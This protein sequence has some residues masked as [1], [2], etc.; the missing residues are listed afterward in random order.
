[1]YE[2]PYGNSQQLNLDW[3]LNK[4]KEFENSGASSADMKSIA[5]ALL[6]ASYDAGSAY[7]VNDVVYNDTLKT[8]YICN[9]AIPV[10]GEPWDAT[11]W[12]AFRV[13]EVLTFLFNTI[14]NLPSDNIANNS[15][16]TGT[17]LTAALNALVEDIKYS[18]HYLQQKKNGVYTDVIPIEDTPS[19]NSDRLASSKAAYD[20]KGAINYVLFPTGNQ[21]DR[22]AEIQAKLNTYGICELAEGEYYISAPIVMGDGQTLK[23]RNR[24]SIIHAPSATG[25]IDILNNVTNVT[26]VGLQLKGDNT[27]RPSVEGTDYPYGINFA[28]GTSASATIDNCY[29]NGLNRGI[30]TVSG[31]SVG[32][33]TNLSISDCAFKYCNVGIYFQPN[34]EYYS[35]TNCTFTK[36]FFGAEVS[37]GNNKFAC[38]T[39]SSNSIGLILYADNGSPQNN[40]HGSAVGCSFNHNTNKGISASNITYGYVF[41]ACNIFY[42]D[43]GL[44]NSSGI[45]FESCIIMGHSSADNH[46]DIIL[47]NCSGSVTFNDCIYI[48]EPTIT[49][50]NSP[51][52]S[53]MN[54][55]TID[56]EIVGSGLRELSKTYTTNSCVTETAFNRIDFYEY[57]QLL[58]VYL[59]LQITGD[60]GA[61]F[62]TIGHVNLSRNLANAFRV[63]VSSTE[64]TLAPV[65]FSIMANGDI[66]I[67]NYDAN[68]PSTDFYRATFVVPM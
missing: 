33:V 17:G 53:F 3:I 65:L 42:G 11:H 7:A 31:A 9:T 50:T 29:F 25:A 63:T 19:N 2:Y 14:Q 4:V 37:G 10:G 66:T 30:V 58:I 51:Y 6:S 38:C 32:D 47:L 23:G 40:G 13:G 64:L 16:V 59:N 27:N 26:V 56:G 57:G 62:V 44:T 36:C 48:N 15:N 67:Y 54:C 12:D 18:N 22:K 55:K 61:N 1:M 49:T 8:L 60:P 41:S 28:S 46:S 20:L 52:L 21:T 5:N 43:I 68:N 45:I 35:V 34:G 39:F 24:N